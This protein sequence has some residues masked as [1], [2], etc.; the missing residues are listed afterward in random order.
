MN[1]RG[2]SAADY[3]LILAVWRR[4]AEAT[5]LFLSPHDIEA[6]E[7]D[8]AKYL[9]QMSDLRVAY[10]G[11]RVLG[12]VALEG[13]TIEM[14]FVDAAYLGQGIGSS[15]LSDITAGRGYVR[16]DV[17]EQNPTGHAFYKAKGFTQIGRSET[18]GEGRPFPILHLERHTSG[19]Q[20]LQ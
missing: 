16:V 6:I 11:T 10:D 4:S 20:Q 9:P 19:H 5:H 13:D 8:V 2:A 17:N 12:F 15:L 14:L 18:D 7:L 3:P 1:I